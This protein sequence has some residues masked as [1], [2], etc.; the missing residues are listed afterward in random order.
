MENLARAS[1][2][3]RHQVHEDGESSETVGKD[4]QRHG[5]ETITE[6]TKM[7]F[8]INSNIN[9]LSAYNSVSQA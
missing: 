1:L 3:S 4:V 6:E 2:A 5:S 7:A 9:A 8:R